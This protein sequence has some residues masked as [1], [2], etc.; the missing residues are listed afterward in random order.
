MAST[1]EKSGRPIVVVTGMGIV[2]SLGAGK[3]DNWDKLTAG[4]SGIRSITGSPIGSPSCIREM[5][6]V[7][8]RHAVKAHTERFP[9][10]KANEDVESVK[11]AMGTSDRQLLEEI[12]RKLSTPPQ[13]G[14]QASL[15]A[16]T[17]NDEKVLEA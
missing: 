17:R 1:R 11:G 10:A 6:D 15:R 16:Y 13:I 2:T 12:L 7:A 9:M 14:D 5:L 8:A 3:A 4:H